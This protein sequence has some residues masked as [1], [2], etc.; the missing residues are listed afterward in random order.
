MYPL[1]VSES[2]AQDIGICSLCDAMNLHS[3]AEDTSIWSCASN[4][5]ISLECNWKGVTCDANYAVTEI[6]ISYPYLD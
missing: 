1:A 5:P 4:R 2:S 3:W 6:V